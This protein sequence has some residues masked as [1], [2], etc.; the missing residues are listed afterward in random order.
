MSWNRVLE[1]PLYL[2]ESL[3]GHGVMDGCGVKGVN[4]SFFTRRTHRISY[5]SGC[6]PWVGFVIHVLL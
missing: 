3:F 4:E 1:Q 6:I 2:I 5:P